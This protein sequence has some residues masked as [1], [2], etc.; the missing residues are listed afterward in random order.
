[1]HARRPSESRIWV[2][3]SFVV[4]H[5]SPFPTACHAICGVS[6]VYDA[7][8][9]L[10]TKIVNVCAIL[11][12]KLY[13]C[14]LCVFKKAIKSINGVPRAKDTAFQSLFVKEFKT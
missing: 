7:I 1:M 14:A 9:M 13:C 2:R 10:Q 8:D 11:Y 4:E 5:K 3:I 12:A 6:L